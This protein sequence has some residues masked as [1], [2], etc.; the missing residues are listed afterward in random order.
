[1]S[2]IKYSTVQYST[3][4]YSTVQYS[5]VHVNPDGRLNAEIAGSN[6]AD[7]MVVLLLCLLLVV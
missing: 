2:C 6:P 1:M 3:V 4:Q 7:G 5:T